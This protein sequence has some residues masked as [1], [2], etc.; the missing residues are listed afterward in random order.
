M[1]NSGFAKASRTSRQNPSIIDV[2]NAKLD[3]LVN[4]IAMKYVPS[5]YR[6]SILYGK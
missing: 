4:S 6:E 1:K 2:N 5:G 3:K